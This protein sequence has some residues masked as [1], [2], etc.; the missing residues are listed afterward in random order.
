MLK[1]IFIFINVIGILILSIF[2]VDKTKIT[3]TACESKICDVFQSESKEV[4]IKINNK[5]LSGPGRLK[6]DLSNASGIKLIEKDSDGAS[7]T[8]KNNEGLFIW[9]D[10]P[11][12]KNIEITYILNPNDSSV[13]LKEI[14][15]TFSYINGNDRVKYEIDTLRI[16]VI[17]QEKNEKEISVKVDRAIEFND[18]EYIVKIHVVKGKHNGFARIKDILPKD[19][20]ASPI[21]SAGAIFKNID[22]SAKFIWSD[23]HSSIES[24]TVSYKLVNLANNDTSFKIDGVYASEKLIEDGYNSGIPIPTTF[25]QPKSDQFS[26]NELRND[27]TKKLELFENE[28]EDST[29]TTQEIISFDEIETE[30]D[31]FS[32]NEIIE[33]KKS[34]LEDSNN[35][36]SKIEKESELEKI[37][38][39]EI[40]LSNSSSNII[41]P[42]KTIN[43]IN[44]K[45]QVLAAHRIASKKDIYKQFKFEGNYDL[46]NHEGW[47]KYTT[48][49][50]KEYK[51][52]R[53]KR[54]SLKT[55]EF[56]GPFVTAYNYGERI[57][58]Q[59]ALIVTN[60]KWIQ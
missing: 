22:G 15:G 50:Y 25:Y 56:P 53:D 1:S 27:T 28:I 31:T 16:N 38:E 18:G 48:G 47:I 24:F 30:D 19:Y 55:H 29:I 5:E 60:Q 39:N 11:K 42:N 35:V 2:N 45:V 23:L 4:S 49:L 21:E 37:I 8:F 46:E 43:S 51:S 9:Y 13:G 58:V 32:E 33:N 26:Y 7:F 54:N 36:S 52:A 34:N 44:Y 6:L 14:T 12:N 57:T 40:L 3:H 10:L 41:T 20:I 17:K 59:E